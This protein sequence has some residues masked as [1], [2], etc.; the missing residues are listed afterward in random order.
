[1]AVKDF[2]MGGVMITEQ[3]PGYHP[4][5][6]TP[7]SLT[8]YRGGQLCIDFTEDCY[9]LT[10]GVVLEM[11]EGNLR[12]IVWADPETEDPTHTIVIEKAKPKESNND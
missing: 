4:H 11:N 7:T 6:S 2:V 1:M 9:G 8:Y 10:N 12:V 5:R 3:E